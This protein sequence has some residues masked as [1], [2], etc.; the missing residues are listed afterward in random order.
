MN[1][2]LFTHNLFSRVIFAKAHVNFVSRSGR[3]P[4]YMKMH[5]LWDPPFADCVHHDPGSQ[6]LAAL[7]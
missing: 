6:R 3:T 7:C 4:S 1:P 2:D 5:N